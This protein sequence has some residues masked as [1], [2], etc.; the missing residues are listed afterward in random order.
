MSDFNNF[1]KQ[2][3]VAS[4]RKGKENA[5]KKADMVSFQGEMKRGITL[6][7]VSSEQATVTSNTIQGH[8]FE[9]GYSGLEPLTPL[10]R[11]WA[12]TKGV[13][14]NETQGNMKV[15]YGKTAFHDIEQFMFNSIPTEAEVKAELDRVIKSTMRGGTVYG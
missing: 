7:K 10:L 2:G 14:V 3:L 5:S 13:K 4:A 15:Y 6:N 1:A 11:A 8:R 9:T 12:E